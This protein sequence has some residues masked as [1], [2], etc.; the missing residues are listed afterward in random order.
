MLSGAHRLLFVLLWAAG[1]W[2]LWRQGFGFGLFP[3]Q[4]MS[5]TWWL[6]WNKFTPLKRDPQLKSLTSSFFQ[7]QGSSRSG[8]ANLTLLLIDYFLCVH[9][10]L[11]QHSLLLQPDFIHGSCNSPSTGWWVAEILEAVLILSLGFC[12]QVCTVQAGCWCQG[13][14]TSLAFIPSHHLSLLQYTPLE[15]INK[16]TSCLL[17]NIIQLNDC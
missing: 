7:V 16:N 9:I 17:V 14:L 6:G 11:S 2:D 1:V 13:L 10:V 4:S 8:V 3:P 12:E 15:T 5:K